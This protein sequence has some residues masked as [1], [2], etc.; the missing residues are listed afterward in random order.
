LQAAAGLAESAK[1]IKGVADV[2]GQVPDGTTADD[3]RK[4]VLDVR[5]R[6]QGGR[7]AVVALFS[8]VNGKPLTVIATNEAAR[9]RGLMAGELVR[10]AAKSLGGGGGGKPDVA[11]G[12]GQNP[13]AV[14]EAVVAVERLVADTAK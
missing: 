1:D 4:L 14:G 3:Q 8:G 2:T 9:E 12:G 5:G 11:Q 13:A 6:N 10:T 7:A